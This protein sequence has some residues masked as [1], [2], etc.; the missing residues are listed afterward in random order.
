MAQSIKISKANETDIRSTEILLEL[1]ERIFC[2]DGIDDMPIFKKIWH[3]MGYPTIIPSED[4]AVIKLEI[5]RR[6]FINCSGRWV[7]VINTAD[8]MVNQI[9]SNEVS[10]IELHPFIKRAV[11]NSILGE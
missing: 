4:A 1:L 6:Y 5:I 8:V 3:E 10:F 11:S 7:K 2:G 9:C